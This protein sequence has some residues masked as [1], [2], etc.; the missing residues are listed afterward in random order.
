MHALQRV[1]LGALIC[2]AT[3]TPASAQAKFAVIHGA[4][5]AKYEEWTNAL[6]KQKLRPA[7]LSIAEI[8]GEPTYAAVAVANP[9][10]Q[11]WAV[12]RDLTAQEYQQ[13]FNAQNAKGLR[14]ICVVGYRRGEAINYAAIFLKDNANAWHARH[15]MD[16]KVNQEAFD[17]FTKIG[18]RPVQASVHQVG[19]GVHFSYVFVKDDVR[20]WI[21]QSGLTA[22]QYQKLIEDQAK[23]NVHPV[24]VSAY[25]TKNGTRFAAI[26]VEDT[27]ERSWSTKHHLTA[28]QYQA[29][30]DEMTGKGFQPTQLCA[31]PWDD[32][33]R[34]LVV[35]VKDK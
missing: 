25:A 2:L 24:S 7:S 34:Y 18:Y 23:K 28:K 19:D 8:K 3:P 16:A 21:S 17:S 10:G 11:A 31:Y 1:A 32:E 22:D 4:S 35:F 27:Q 14:P 5:A 9:F 26:L 20:N 6:D 12:A 30:F 33:A 29:Y 15:G 13:E